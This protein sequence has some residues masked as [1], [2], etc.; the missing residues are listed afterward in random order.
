MEKQVGVGVKYISV[1]N[2]I[3]DSQ[4][5]LLIKSGNYPTFFR[6]TIFSKILDNSKNSDK[7]VIID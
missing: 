4:P 6:A 7:S 3:F 2:T 5:K 1:G